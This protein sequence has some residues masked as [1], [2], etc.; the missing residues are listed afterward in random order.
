MS[1]LI[2]TFR[3]HPNDKD[4]SPASAL[5]FDD[6]QQGI[7]AVASTNGGVSLY[8]CSSDRLFS[9]PSFDSSA[10]GRA[11]PAVQVPTSTDASCV[12]VSLAWMPGELTLA[13]GMEDGNVSLWSVTKN[14]GKSSPL[15]SSGSN[16]LQVKIL[17]SNKTSH[18]SPVILLD[19]SADGTRFVSGDK[20]GNVTLWKVQPKGKVLAKSWYKKESPVTDVIW[21]CFNGG[22]VCFANIIIFLFC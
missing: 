13:M 20:A 18:S 2:S 4:S 5:A 22:Q 11:N 17:S 7:L 12:V 9:A 14:N 3:C 8:D 6:A 1:R 19:W 16:Q 10:C 21:C 15:S